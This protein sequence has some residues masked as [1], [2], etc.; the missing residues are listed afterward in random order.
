MS[1]NTIILP[2][3]TLDLN[4]LSRLST[5]EDYLSYYI[6]LSEINDT[7]SWVKADF[8]VFML[9]KM[10]ADSLL[11]LSRDLKQPFGTVDNYIRT[12]RAFP[13]DKRNSAMSFSHHFKSSFADR[14]DDKTKTF[15]T[16]KRFDWIN[17]AQDEKMST[18]TLQANISEEKEKTENP[19]LG[20]LCS[21][22]GKPNDKLQ[23]WT[24]AS[25][26]TGKRIINLHLHEVC[27]VEILKFIYDGHKETTPAEPPKSDVGVE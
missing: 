1:E 13:T 24:M 26:G 11:A 18:R 4:V 25:P 15:L 8:L 21:H 19:D 14:Y 16:N 20:V 22:C 5:Y 27:L 6:Q 17:R 10:G 3:S 9:K 12:A 23:K 7:V 2:N